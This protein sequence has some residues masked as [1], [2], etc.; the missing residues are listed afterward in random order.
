MNP[1]GWR[2]SA[3]SNRKASAE[4]SPLYASTIAFEDSRNAKSSI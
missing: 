4:R 1:L 2:A 3:G